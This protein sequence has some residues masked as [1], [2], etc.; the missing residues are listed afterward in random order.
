MIDSLF[1]W[2]SEAAV[3]RIAVAL[4]HFFWQG[5]LVAV[6]TSLLLALFCDGALGAR[7]RSL[8]SLRYLIACCSLALMAMLPVTTWLIL[9]PVESVRSSADSASPNIALLEGSVSRDQLEVAGHEAQDSTPLPADYHLSD[10]GESEA[11]AAT[12]QPT[13]PFGNRRESR[14]FAR[15][16][17]WFFWFW[18]AG[19]TGLALWHG[20]GWMLSRR[21]KRRG[22]DAPAEVSAAMQSLA[23]RLGLNHSISIRKTVDSAS[24]IVIGL[25]K[26]VLLIPASV[27]SG[28]TPTEL[29]AVLA[30]E[31]AHVKRH[32]YLVNLL[33][34]MV[35]TLLFYHPAVWWISHHIRIEREYCADDLALK[36]CGN[37]ETY[38][39]SLVAIAEISIATPRYA[40]AAT[41]GRLMARVQRLLPLDEPVRDK[42]V[43]PTAPAGLALLVLLV[44]LTIGSV[45]VPTILAD[46]TGQAEPTT[47]PGRAP[48]VEADGDERRAKRT[49]LYGDR[50]PNGA[51]ARMG[52]V[53][54]RQGSIVWDVA[55]SPDGKLIA[56]AG[57]DHSVCLWEAD[58]GKPLFR[59]QSRDWD[60]RSV[61]FAPDGKNMAAAGSGS[62]RVFDVNTREETN[63]F[64][65]ERVRQ[66]R[67]TPDGKEL[68]AVC[69]MYAT[70]GGKMSDSEGLVRFLDAATGKERLQITTHG[71]YISSIAVAGQAN[72]I[73]T[74]SHDNTVRLWDRSTNE[75]LQR[76]TIVDGLDDKWLHYDLQSCVALSPDGAII[77]FSRPD[78]T[79]QLARTVT[80]EVVQRL[81]GHEDLVCS[82]AFSADG[83]TLVSGGRDETVR[84]WSV[85]SGRQ[86]QRSSGHESWVECVDYSPLGKTIVSG[87]Q[88]HTV[89]VWDTSTGEEARPFK[90]HGHWIFAA[91]LS[92]DGRRAATAGCE[93]ISLWDAATGKRLHRI[94]QPKWVGT[95]S[96]S[97]DGTRLAAGS[98][99]GKVALFDSE[100]GELIRESRGHA[101]A[102]G[103]VRFLVGGQALITA[104]D[105]GTARLWDVV[106]GRTVRRLPV[107]LSEARATAVSDDGKLIATITNDGRIQLAETATG[108]L[109][110]AL[111]HPGRNIRATAFS[112]DAT[113]FVTVGDAPLRT[114]LFGAAPPTST[115]AAA[116][117]WDVNTGKTIHRLERD[118]D[119]IGFT[120]HRR[121]EIHH[122][123]FSPD[124]QTLATAEADGTVVMYD[125][126]TGDARGTL[127]GHTSQVTGLS[128]SADGRFLTSAG[129]DD[130]TAL[131]WD[132][133]ED[134]AEEHRPGHQD[135]SATGSSVDS[136]IQPLHEVTIRILG[137]KKKKPLKSIDVTANR[138]R[139]KDAAAK[140]TTDLA[141][142]VRMKLTPGHY[143]IALASESEVPYLTIPVGYAAHPATYSRWIRVKAEADSQEF[144]FNLADACQVT[145]RAVDVET[146]RGIP[147]V[148]FATEN[149]TAEQWA[150]PIDGDNLG[151]ERI[152]VSALRLKPD[153][154]KTD[155]D[156]VFQCLLGP[157]PGWTYF[158]WNAPDEYEEVQRDEVEI[159]TSNGRR[160]AE[161]TFKLRRKPPGR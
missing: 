49:D 34:V 145:L 28:L 16:L 78:N 65:V 8:A 75:Q 90:A 108:E 109:L 5:V 64:D 68:V 21:L 159:D 82:I 73:A 58:T 40:L 31:L 138:Q 130:L 56:S 53:R 156:G 62:V 126:G 103:L 61:T 136:A 115:A 98:S 100:T 117:L 143:Y 112:P 121:R 127:K 10:R 11:V 151:A 79:I 155:K 123:A 87:S 48:P 63:R 135:A 147:G 96:F 70:R 59:F 74:A 95:V 22:V 102:V 94:D 140:G 113:L 77:A 54:F 141:G 67:Y 157:C 120:E 111:R 1:P 33:Q 146:G 57:D 160:T 36:V 93:G 29:E 92:P 69:G 71:G 88:D 9:A 152:P 12:Q 32:D 128:F 142:E 46:S 134:R 119:S 15:S 132:L 154:M 66:V 114:G 38:A 7:T 44:A 3:H 133:S 37:E 42:Q 81:E 60:V 129:S 104:S 72:T 41:G 153:S 4:L 25:F 110:R 13:S 51:V 83:Q 18:A 19:T 124:G 20:T 106:T 101:K 84:L 45:V 150:Q 86:L 14:L 80:G 161:Y 99:D 39:R 85:A 17:S 30:H 125:V 55:I 149:A 137:G 91:A 89:R 50:L 43:F 139:R 158:V 24:P 122:V 131:V 97:P 148:V 27:I 116:C 6:G 105:D 76:W 144:T 26:P 52:T 23:K 107:T 47:L 35:E 2:L 118:P